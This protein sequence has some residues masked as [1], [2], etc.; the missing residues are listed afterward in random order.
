MHGH[1]REYDTLKSPIKTA[2]LGEI[3]KLGSNI[4]SLCLDL[5]G[6]YIGF[7]LDTPKQESRVKT[8]LVRVSIRK[9]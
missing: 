8:C 1:I 9:T 4:E 7:L 5:T 6:V 2:I 3:S